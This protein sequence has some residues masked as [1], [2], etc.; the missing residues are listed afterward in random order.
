MSLSFNAKGIYLL[1]MRTPM[2]YLY[3]FTFIF[4]SIL[5]SSWWFF[6]YTP[7]MRSI[8]NLYQTLD[9]MHQKTFMAKRTE[10]ELAALT[11]S[12][13]ELKISVQNYSS[14]QSQKSMT[15]QTLALIADTALQNGMLVNVCKLS[16]QTNSSSPSGQ[17]TFAC[18]G[19][20]DQLIIFFE[21]LKN[22]KRMIDCYSCELARAEN[23]IFAA[24]I[25]F[26]I[27]YV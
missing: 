17:I 21:T 13:A 2:R 16:G 9:Q 24:Q 12:I 15:Q 5:M 11:K 3:L 6:L 7:T 1:L 18:R 26:D 20:L 25:V 4:L 8:E 22:S 10:R 23:D 19:T 14:K 27:L